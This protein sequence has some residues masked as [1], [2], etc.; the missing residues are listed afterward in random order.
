MDTLLKKVVNLTFGKGSQSQGSM[1]ISLKLKKHPIMIR[2]YLLVV[3]FLVLSVHWTFAQS[4]TEVS[5]S[6]GIDHTHDPG[7]VVFGGGAAVLD[8]DND[9]WEDLYLTGGAQRDVLYKNNGDGTFAEVGLTAGLGSTADRVTTGV[10]AGDIDNDGYRDIFVTARCFVTD[11][12]ANAPNYLFKNNG[13]GTFTDISMS[14]G[15]AVDTAFSCSATFGD[16][17]IDGDL[18][19]YVSNFFFEPFNLVTDTNGSFYQGGV[20]FTGEPNDFYQN[21]G[22]GTFTEV[23]A[24]MGIADVGTTWQSTFTDYDGDSDLDIYVA[25]DFGNT[26]DLP[27]NEMYQNQYPTNSFNTVG[28]AT[29]SNVGMF[30]MGTAVGDFN[31]DGWLDYYVSNLGQ[32]V[33]YQ[34]TGTAS[35]I[36]VTSSAGISNGVH[37]TPNGKTSIAYLPNSGFL[38]TD[39]VWL[40]ACH[41]M[42]AYCDTIVIVMDVIDTFP[43]SFGTRVEDT[44]FMSVYQGNLWSLGFVTQN[45]LT[46]DTL[47]SAGVGGIWGLSFETDNIGLVTWGVNFWDYDNDTYLD[48]FESNGS[49]VY[50][51]T[52]I[53]G[54]YP[55]PFVGINPSALYHNDGD[56]TF[57]NVA[58]IEGFAD[59]DDFSVSK[60]SVT[61]DYDKDG[62]LDLFVVNHKYPD[63][64]ITHSPP[65]CYLYRNDQGN[66]NNWLKVKLQGTTNNRDGIGSRVSITAGGRTFIREIGGGS[67][68]H[69][70]NSNIAHFGLGSIDTIDNLTVTWLGGEKH[71]I[72]TPFPANQTIEIIENTLTVPIKVV[73]EGAYIQAT[74]VMST[75]LAANDLLPLSQPFNQLPW[76]YTGT[77]S[78][79]EI[80]SNM[81]DWVL[82]ELREKNPSYALV[83]Q[84]AALLM[85]DGIVLDVEGSLGAN[86]V[87][88]PAEKYHI[89]VKARSH[90][91]VISPITLL[92]PDLNIYDFSTSE[93]Q[94]QGTAQL[95]EVAPGVY[96]MN[97]GDYNH[98][99]LVTVGDFNLYQTQASLINQYLASDGSKDGNVTVTDFNLFQP[100]ASLIGAE[101]IRY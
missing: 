38:G 13:D 68:C 22:D 90:L 89:V 77:E 5:I 44:L 56:A 60:G 24:M 30:A 12:N 28:A 73:L 10:I 40:Q 36:D 8:F 78:I 69:S 74:G 1:L 20:D 55:F 76:S 35:F 37:T 94:A 80:P 27:D 83:S 64:Y 31:E 100:N 59:S 84:R 99:G 17:D 79:A 96:A 65:H 62:D 86:F 75:T 91:G 92:M 70:H 3:I 81:V 58:Q 72:A 26:T 29:N 6:A 15:I 33:L 41:N 23:G 42:S 48:I 19:I 43:S 4:F 97:A 25:N 51:N 93:T 47:Y 32:N 53:Y 14:A 39:T 9:G 87:G 82:I 2:C 61:F 45:Y 50:L 95:T 66:A 57:T 98:D 21:N 88:V 46:L 85:D 101:P 18:D 52:Y 63:T 34:S 49:L 67:G 54:Y 71:L 11:F 7:D 16:F